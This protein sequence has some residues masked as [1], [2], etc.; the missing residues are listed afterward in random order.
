MF[1]NVPLLVQNVNAIPGM[2]DHDIVC[3]D[4]CI[5]SQK[6]K[7]PRRKIFLYKKADFEKISEDLT[8]YADTVTEERYRNSSVEELWMGFK[9]TLLSVMERHIPSKMVRQNVVN[10]GSNNLI[11]ELLG[12]SVEPTTGLVGQGQRMTG[13]ISETSVALQIDEVGE[14]LATNNAKPFWSFIKSFRQSTTGDSA[15]NTINGV[16]TTA[17]EKANA[18][19]KK[20][21][22]I[23]T[24]ED[25]QN[26]PSLKQ[27]NPPPMPQINVTTEGILKLLRDLKSAKS[28][29]PRYHHA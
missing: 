9:Y 15:L 5:S 27:E 7:Q 1:T 11:K 22:S 28:T 10:H 23:F 21:Q 29:W 4:F 2:S 3:V 20:F 18:L 14:N 13:K 12:V 25:C 24:E 26:L 6:I 19:N 16:A 17:V 8:N